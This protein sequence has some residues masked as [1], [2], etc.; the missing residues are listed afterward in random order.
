LTRC[1]FIWDSRKSIVIGPAILCSINF[2]LEI[3]AVV[4]EI[5]GDISVLTRSLRNG[6]PANT[7]A[8]MITLVV[9]ASVIFAN[10]LL[11]G[12]IAGRIWRLS[13]IVNCY[14]ESDKVN[15]TD[16]KQI[17]RLVTIMVESGALYPISIIAALVIELQLDLGVDRLNPV[18]AQMVGIAP[19]LIL[20]RVDLGSSIENPQDQSKSTTSAR[21]W[22][23]SPED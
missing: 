11:T 16:S 2:G 12:L 17:Y 13:Q 3:T 5:E 4:L 10:I 20:V 15:K 7:T 18:V 21:L 19:T 23:A 14:P 22:R 1:Y 9:G 6:S 8:T